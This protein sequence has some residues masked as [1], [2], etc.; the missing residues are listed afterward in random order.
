MLKLSLWLLMISRIFAGGTIKCT[1]ILRQTILFDKNMPSLYTHKS[2]SVDDKLKES[3]YSAE[4]IF[5]RSH[6]NKK[7]WNDMHNV[8]KTIN[9]LN[10]NRSNYKYTDNI[11]YDK[12]WIRLNFDNYVNHKQKLFLPNAASRGFI[13]RA[14]LYMCKEYDYNPRKII[15]KEILLKWFYEYPPCKCEKYHNEIIKKLQNTNNIFISKYNKK[16]R[17]LAKYLE[18]L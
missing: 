9:N 10:V 16:T 8:I 1:N 2:F 6:L 5:P 14:I 7:D 3:V 17:V 11:T 18:N 4:H 13:S 15:D 12:N